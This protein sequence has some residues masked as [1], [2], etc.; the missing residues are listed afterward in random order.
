MLLPCIIMFDRNRTL[1]TDTK[2]VT[3]LSQIHNKSLAGGFPRQHNEDEF[4]Y[5]PQII[6]IICQ[7]KTNQNRIN[8]KL[9]ALCCVRDLALVPKHTDHTFSLF[10]RTQTSRNTL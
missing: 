6:S 10:Q 9:F 1:V 2:T 7:K 8:D 3:R 5:L 4:Y